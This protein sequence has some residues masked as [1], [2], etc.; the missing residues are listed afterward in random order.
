[1]NKGLV[2]LLAVAWLAS[3]FVAHRVGGSKYEAKMVMVEKVVAG[4]TERVEVPVYIDSSASGAANA[5]G[6]NQGPD[7]LQP[8]ETRRSS[9]RRSAPLIEISGSE[10]NDDNDIAATPSNL[11]D[12]LSNNDPVTRMREFG[13]ILQ[14][15]DDADFPALLGS[16][17]DMPEANDRYR[18]YNILLYAWA[19][20]DGQVAADFAQEKL[21]TTDNGRDSWRKGFNMQNVLSGWATQD[22][23]GALAWAK[24][25]YDPKDAPA[26]MKGRGNRG[27]GGDTPK[28]DE[29]EER[30][31]NPYVVGIINGL[32]KSDP[33]RAANL[34][35]ELPYGRNRGMAVDS[36]LKSLLQNGTS[37]AMNWAATLEDEKLQNGV[38]QRVAGRIAEDDPAGAANW[39]NS[40]GS[41]AI[42]KDAMASIVST[43]ARKD[44]DEA[45]AWLEEV[46]AGPERDPSVSALADRMS[47][48]DPQEALIWAGTISD[49]ERRRKKLEDIAERWIRRD[50]DAARE[51][52]GE[53]AVPRPEANQ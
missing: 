47:R 18:E 23:D 25:N 20:R 31:D 6:L 42:K 3:M 5:L 52:L 8:G 44:I 32:A 13:S 28:P 37:D 34:V 24:T 27:R 39:V 43:W 12:A 2:V 7:D 29:G 53:D 1:M 21:K 35:S 4:K 11:R 36:V 48:E 19:Q 30:V 33:S 51:F 50:A 14:N 16:F 41:D 26:W 10:G 17:E 45:A 38:V 9:S 22:A 46:P 15:L 40:L 49:T